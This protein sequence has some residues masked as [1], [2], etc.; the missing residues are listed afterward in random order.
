MTDSSKCAHPA[1]KCHVKAD[2]PHGKYCSEHCKSA[3]D[4]TEL[5]CECHCPACDQVNA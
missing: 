1:C 5:R 4:K 3:A 2:A